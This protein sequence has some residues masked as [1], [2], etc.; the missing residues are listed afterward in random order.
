MEAT[1]VRPFCSLVALTKLFPAMTWGQNP[2]DYSVTVGG[3]GHNL[4]LFHYAQLW[5]SAIR[6]LEAPSS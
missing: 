2:T 3:C 5:Q 6:V 4:R 1:L